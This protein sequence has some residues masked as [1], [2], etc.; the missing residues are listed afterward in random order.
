MNWLGSEPAWVGHFSNRHRAGL[1]GIP[2]YAIWLM[3]LSL[4]P[5]SSQ[6]YCA[7]P[8]PPAS[9]SESDISAYVQGMEEYPR[10]LHNER[11]LQPLGAGTLS[12]AEKER[13]NEEIDAIRDATFQEMSAVINRVRSS[14]T[15]AASGAGGATASGPSGGSSGV[16]CAQLERDS[17]A[18]MKSIEA[19][20]QGAGLCQSY[21]LAVELGQVGVEMY[22]S[23]RILDPS[24]EQLRAAHKMIQDGQE[25]Q[26][27]T[28]SR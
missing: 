5:I 14:G 10:C 8:G 28:C 24:G 20:M 12:W 7:K 17:M 18:R 3:L 23:C 4:V 27:N 25:G 19:R 13:R 2:R 15:A 21:K 6:A 16:D 9:A 11:V 22:S 1:L 26:R